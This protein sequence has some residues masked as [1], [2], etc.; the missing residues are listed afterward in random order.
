M[1]TLKYSSKTK[2]IVYNPACKTHG[3]ENVRWVE[4]VNYGLRLVGF[5]DDIVG[6]RH[7]GWFTDDDGGNDEIYRGIVYQ[8]PGRDLTEQYVYGYADPDNEGCALVCFDI[9]TDKDEAA[10]R[11][12]NFAERCAE[13]AR[14]YNRTWQAGRRYRDL[15]DEIKDTR[16]KALA[17][18]AEMH[19]ARK[20]K[21][22]APMICAT[23]RERFLSLYK[24]IQKMREERAELLDSY[25]QH[26]GF[27]D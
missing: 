8:L 20:V 24:S 15:D 9:T 13:Y 2:H 16:R 27:A 25:G 3:Y 10:R 17:L 14:D 21:L 26:E 7:K 4:N 18:G 11:A 6:L 1:S 5:A 23:L 12:D 22:N 19:E